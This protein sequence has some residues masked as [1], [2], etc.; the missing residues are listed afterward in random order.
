[1]TVSGG[2]GGLD[3]AFSISDA[4]IGANILVRG[5]VAETTN[6]LRV[7]EIVTAATQLP[8]GV[9]MASTSTDDTEIPVRVSGI[10]ML[11]VDGN[12]GAIDIGDSI[13]GN[14]TGQGVKAAA[15]DENQYKAI[16]YALAP[17]AAD[18]DVIPVLIDR[19]HISEGVAD[20]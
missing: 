15:P 19:H 7:A 9:T 11:E 20:V 5:D 14:A 13:V 12:A 10:A 1:M 3:I 16:G 6:V 2:V 8:I 18:G 17:S 4:A